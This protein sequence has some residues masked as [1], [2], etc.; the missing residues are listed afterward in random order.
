MLL[1]RP[2]PRP[3]R[4]FR[5][6]LMSMITAL[7][8]AVLG[9]GVAGAFTPA[10]AVDPA[11][12]VLVFSKTA[13]FRHSSIGPGIAAIQQLGAAN[14]FTV[15]ATEDAAAFTT[16]N[17][18]QY[19][20]VVFLSTTGDV[21]NASQQTAFEGYIRAGG[22]YVGI[23]AASDTEYSWPWYG[24]LVGAYFAGH[25]APQQATIKVEDRTHPSTTHLGNTWVRT[26]EWYDYNRNPRSA[27]NVLATLDESTYSGGNMGADHPIAW[28]HHFDGGRSWYTGGGH[29]DSSYTEPAFRTHL[30]GGIRWA[31][32]VATLPTG[33]FN[34]VT[35]AKGVPE[36]GEPMSIAVLPNRS[37][38]HTARN[39][40]LRLTDAAGNTQ[41]SATIPVYTG[42]EEGLQ[43]VAIDPGFATNRFVF[44]YYSPVLPAGAPG[45][46]RLSRYVLRADGTLDLG[47]Q[48]NVLDV[49]ASRGLCCHVG[50]DID[51]DAAGNLF[52]STGDDTNPFE[53]SG[54]T[55][56]DE[57]PG[58][59]AYD[60]Q[61]SSANTNDLRG[62]L[63]RIKV[64]P[65]GTY[66]IPSGNM[67]APG[68]PQTRPEIYA[69]G[70]RNP[71]RMSVD[72][73]TGIVY[74]GDYGPDGGA[75]HRG[76]A[77]QVEFNRVT[78]PGNYGWPY[79]TGNNDAYRDYT[80]PSGPVGAVFD[81]AGGPTN[82]S[83]NNT[84][85]TQLPPAIP[86]WIT[87]GG[88]SSPPEFGGGSESPMGGPVYRYNPNNPSTTKFPASLNGR[89]FAGE[90]GRRWIKTID[91]N[92][93]GS[94][95]AIKPF[96]WTGTQVMDMEFGPDGALYVLDYGDGGFF[97][98]NE[99][100]ALYRIDYVSGNQAPTAVASANPT[101]G[102]VPLTVSFT[103]NTSTDPEGDPLTYAWDFQ[104][105]GST[106]STAANPT[107]TYTTAG[108]FSAKLTVTDPSGASGTTN[109]PISVGNTA[110]TVTITAPANGQV[111]TPGDTIPYTISVVDPDDGTIDCADVSVTYGLGHDSHGHAETTQAGCSGTITTTADG[112]HGAD[113]NIYGSWSA[114][115]TD[116]S[117]LTT[118]SSAVT[119]PAN[120]QAEHYGTMS[121]VQVVDKASARGGK[122]V[123]YI[124]NGDWIRFTPY[125]LTGVTSI[126]ARVASA[127]SGGTIELRAG[128]PTGTLA[129]TVT[130]PATGGWEAWSN[131]TASI[132]NPG[133]S[134]DLYLVFK[135]AG[136]GYLFDLDEWTFVKSGGTTPGDIT[137]GSTATASSIENASHPAS[138]AIDGNMSTRWSSQF[139]DPQSITIDLGEANTVTGV[140]LNWEAAFG[141]AYSI[142][143]SADGTTWRPASFSTTTGDGG[144]DEITFAAAESNTRYVRMTGTQRGT[145]Y[146]YSL[147]EFRVFGSAGS[148]PATTVQAEDAAR[149]GGAVFASDHAGY[150]GTGFVATYG[151]VGSTTAFTVNAASAGSRA[152]TLR[153]A[154][155]GYPTVGTKTL[156]LYVNGGKV[157]QVS[158]PATANWSTW[159]ENTETVNLTA[160]NN[161]ITYKID[162]GDSG[163]VNLDKITVAGG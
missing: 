128:S 47:T 143:T 68:T 160:G 88:A 78:G 23:H 117:G 113:A 66:S 35:L 74:L 30:L 76:P 137:P 157:K 108:S 134:A 55:P 132:T 43:G 90:F 93:D 159:A 81:C 121:G 61:R 40:T 16:A 29:T 144:V 73:T 12:Q 116:N 92:P 129:G 107:F 65:N 52:L 106:D 37:V 44:L 34:Q 39:G 83:P 14:N 8:C 5:L 28:Y 59:E 142:Q 69:M 33:N 118:T 96:P 104:N 56:I 54:S 72:K 140:R 21:L 111:F 89:F 124:N 11:Y 71:F 45:V 115:Y 82:N 27:V 119:Q 105:N 109:V 26:D 3:A 4:R 85:R 97:T 98:G 155:G 9:V 126:N 49:A 158:L 17:L 122:A 46:M 70:F 63:L 86:A 102:G 58:R 48:V 141:R 147:W 125:N 31:A 101:S 135:G 84:G 1:S 120:R 156:S 131:V 162:S 145:P 91:V 38:L 77:G 163:F 75:S 2:S 112:E 127:A 100:S 60:A 62:K 15:T 36:V 20:A 24:N 149:S 146:G 95:G 25:P 148:A 6:R 32:G 110:P 10:S 53:S 136:T 7:A 19:E 57:R 87:Y 22:G 114:T 99:N 79:C 150:T 161:T 67:F 41:V 151:S 153:Y 130:V 64:N 50:G 138:N 103:G 154:N 13:G 51:F 80:F 152:V 42:D 123:G 133:G 18:A 94:R 139:S